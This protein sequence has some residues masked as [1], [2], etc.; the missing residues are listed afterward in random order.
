MIRGLYT[1][2]DIESPNKSLKVNWDIVEKMNKNKGKR[3]TKIIDDCI[4]DDVEFS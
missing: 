2:S 4:L 3:F 1:R